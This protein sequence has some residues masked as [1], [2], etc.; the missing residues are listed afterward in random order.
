MTTQTHTPSTHR[1]KNPSSAGLAARTARFPNGAA[2]RTNA[3][4]TGAG[5]RQS[6]GTVC[7]YHGGNAP[8][9]K[10]KVRLRLEMASDRLARQLLNMTSDPNVADPVKLAATKD[11]L[12]RFNAKITVAVAIS[13]ESFRIDFRERPGQDHPRTA[14]G[15]GSG[16]LS[17]ASV[18]LSCPARGP[19]SCPLADELGR[20]V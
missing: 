19:L 3:M 11:A 12:E 8:A 6:S 10:A 14:R 18:V 1:L 2:R 17:V 13:T 7:G 16:A 20:P 5:I 9:V 4:A 15:P